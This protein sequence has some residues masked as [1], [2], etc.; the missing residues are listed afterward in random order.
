MHHYELHNYS[1][2]NEYVNSE[3]TITTIEGIWTTQVPNNYKPVEGEQPTKPYRF[4]KRADA[5]SILDQLKSHRLND[6]RQNSHIYKSMGYKKPSWKIYKIF[7]ESLE[8][9]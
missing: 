8:N 3:S 4:T 5:V 7:E 2:C 9:S 6:W 1:D